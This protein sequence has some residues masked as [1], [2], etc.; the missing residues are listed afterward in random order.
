M[1]QFRITKYDPNK[2][3]DLGHY[4]DI[5]EWTEFSEVGKKISLEEYEAIEGLYLDAAYELISKSGIKFLNLIGLENYKKLCPYAE[6][7]QIDIS[8]I[9]DVVRSLLRTEYWAKLESQEGFIH[10][11]YDFYMYVGTKDF[12]ESAICKIADSGL[13]VEQMSSPYN[14]NDS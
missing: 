13:Y 3:N 10:I 7:D 6:N 4:L 11:G 12:D 14:E 2:R 1:W 9:R 8:N 5:D